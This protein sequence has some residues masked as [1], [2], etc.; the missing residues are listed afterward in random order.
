MFVVLSGS[1]SYD[2]FLPLCSHKEVP[3]QSYGMHQLRVHGNQEHLKQQTEASQYE[4]V[5]QMQDEEITS[6]C[7]NEDIPDSEENAGECYGGTSFQ[8]NTM[9]LSS[10]VS[11]VDL[12]KKGEKP[13]AKSPSNNSQ[14]VGP[15]FKRI[16]RRSI[17]FVD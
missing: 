17:L 2:S 6:Q 5:A 3:A 8:T 10:L 16:G 12:T 4:S 14:S 15:G 7:S 9:W 13:P 11:T 1:F